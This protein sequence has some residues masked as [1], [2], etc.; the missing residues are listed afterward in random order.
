MRIKC[1]VGETVSRPRTDRELRPRSVD[2]L[3]ARVGP[4]HIS[5]IF[6]SCLY[7]GL[8]ICALSKV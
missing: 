2:G 7:S 8:N 3:C 4:G 5:R 6:L 1:A